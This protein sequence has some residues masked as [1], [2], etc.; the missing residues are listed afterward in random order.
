[1]DVNASFWD[2]LFVGLGGFLLSLAAEFTVRPKTS[3]SRPWQAWGMQFALWGMLFSP[4]VAL[5]GRPWCSACFCL[6]F[7]AI[8]IFVNKAKFHSMREPLLFHDYDYF[9]DVLRFPRLFLPFLGI[10]AFLL[11]ALAVILAIIALW[12][13]PVAPSRWSLRGQ[14]G[15]NLILFLSSL[16]C[17]LLAKKYSP[18]LAHSPV[19]DLYKLGFL[20][21]LA[22][23]G[24]EWSKK[25]FPA[26]PLPPWPGLNCEQHPFLVAI[27][28]ESFFNARQCWPDINK[29]IYADIDL[30]ISEAFLHGQM[31][32]PAWGANTE[33]SEFSFLSGISPARLG[34][35]RFN[36]YRMLAC[37]WRIAALPAHMRSLGYRTICIHPY[38]GS[39]YGRD[40]ILPMLGFD[41]F[42]EIS[43]FRE[44]DRRGPYIG[45][46]AIADMII[47]IQRGA[48]SPTFIFAI[49]MENH[50]P[51]HLEKAPEASANQ[52]IFTRQAP[53]SCEELGIYLRHVR[54]GGK[55][56]AK[57]HKFWSSFRM[58]VSLCFYGDHVPIMPQVWSKLGQPKGDVPYFC[59]SNKKS[60]DSC[61]TLLASSHLSA[62]WLNCLQAEK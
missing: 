40:L 6:S 25:D 60:A 13:E 58:P 47:E 32:T 48:K 26:P 29:E 5:T 43:H 19:A 31:L 1:M 28:S 50:G 12:L 3:A 8:L 18:K 38:I 54:N 51:L 21:F 9:L 39:F 37:G 15:A 27:Q 57:L 10:R 41:E 42:L 59:W 56:L 30:F 23:Y 55:M 34:I 53:E 17:F 45:D 4:L 24:A 44:S 20:P 2:C 49:T 11:C 33:R 22:F 36:P 14:A 62:A 35:G 16:A 52:K 61:E 7:L 46:E